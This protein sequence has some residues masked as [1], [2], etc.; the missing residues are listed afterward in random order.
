MFF[1]SKHFIYNFRLFK[2]YC[3]LSLWLFRVICVIAFEFFKS[4]SNAAAAHD[5]SVRMAIR[6]R[7]YAKS[8]VKQSSRQFA[9]CIDTYMRMRSAYVRR[10]ISMRLGS[11]RGKCS[12]ARDTWRTPLT[13]FASTSGILNRR[14]ILVNVIYF[15]NSVCI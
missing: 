11:R 6:L 12:S 5:C 2:I 10:Q 1:F 13:L 4:S 3:Y 9:P 7:V 15:I 8:D 14:P